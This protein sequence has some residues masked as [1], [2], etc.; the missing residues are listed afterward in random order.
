MITL[1]AWIRVLKAIISKD[2]EITEI[3]EEEKKKVIIENSYREITES[4]TDCRK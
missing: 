1:Y 4:I 3:V 2:T